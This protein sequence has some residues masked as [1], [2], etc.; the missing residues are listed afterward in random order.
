MRVMLLAATVLALSPYLAQAA[1]LTITDDNSSL[2]F[3]IDEPTFN[4]GVP[5]DPVQLPR[6]L[7]WTVDGHRILVYPS[8]PS[9]FLDIGHIHPDAHVAG[10]QI[11][12]QGPLLGYG[13]GATTG[14]VTGGI[15]YT[16]DGGTPGNGMSRISEK[17]D[18]RNNSSGAVSLL[19]TGMGFKPTQASLEV[20]D[21]TGVNITGTTLI[22]FQGISGAVSIT[23]GPPFAPVTVLPVVSFSGFNPLLNQSFSLPAGATLTMVTELKVTPGLSLMAL[24]LFW[25][26]VAAIVFA[27]AMGVVT[28]RRRRQ[29]N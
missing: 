20:P 13:T 7:E 27:T 11:H 22:F 25:L 29:R 15:V 2:K 18:I 10:N 19:L 28:W 6:T 21:L 8:S 14:T 9:T 5:N 1:P 26:A 23:D 12:A 16:V 3:T 24:P 17:V 4:L